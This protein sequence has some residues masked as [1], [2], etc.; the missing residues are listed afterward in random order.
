MKFLDIVKPV[1]PFLPEVSQP[2]RKIPF[3]EKAQWTLGVLVIFLVCCQLP[4]YGVS[5]AKANDP[6]YWM[7]V[8]LASNRGTLMELGI[9]PIVTSGLFMQVLAGAR[10]IDVN[11]QSKED[12]ALYNGAQKLFGILLTIGTAVTYVMS[13]M[14]GDISDVGL[15]N[16]ILIITQL[17]V[18][19][20]MV[21]LMDELLQK[22]YGLG[23]GISLFI[24]TNT[25]ETILWKALSPTTINTGKGTEFEGAIIAFF[26]LMFVRSNKLVALKEAFYRDNLPNLSN[27]MA[28]ILIFA[29]V[30]Y[31]QGWKVDLELQSQRSRQ[32]AMYPIKLF[33]TSNMP[34]ILYSAMI[35]NAYFFSQI[36]FNRYPTNPL[37]RLL[38]VWS[39]SE[40][41]SGGIPVS[42]LVY[43]VSPP[44]S[45]IEAFADPFRFILYLSFILAACAFFSNVWIEISGTSPRDVA[46]QLRDAQMMLR[47]S[48]NTAMVDTL[49]K[50]IPIAAAF[51]GV[52][53]GALTVL[54]DL[55]GA[56]GSGTGILLAVTILYQYR[57][58]YEGQQINPGFDL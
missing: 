48:R 35:S 16:A 12:R 32:T 2:E 44:R 29:V 40:G 30:I 9:S 17:S 45:L 7:R 46:R 38:G 54:A 51:G 36:L 24:A 37:V 18:A 22:G 1:M 20:I 25:C 21:L 13:G 3:R 56:I 11:Q 34:I 50:Y 49:Y 28:T 58:M 8:I 10:M 55:L 6:F 57:E 19:G 14:Y 41:G 43:Y 52:C 33:Y 47:G 53:I 15:G 26:H 4:L 5:G 23:S 39:S 42:G 27:L 31:M